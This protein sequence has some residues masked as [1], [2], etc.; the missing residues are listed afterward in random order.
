MVRFVSYNMLNLF[1]G[2]S[3]EECQR[4]D[5]VYQ[6]IREAD[7][8]VLAVQEIIADGE[9][10]AVVAATRVAELAEATGL[11]CQYAPGQVAV[12]IGNHRV[13]VALLWR[14][15]I[16]PAGGWRAYRARICGTFWRNCIWMWV[17]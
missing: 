17:V 13:H 4:R 15:G 8:D 10:K 11:E 9:D 7:P 3:P 14:S 12:A 16:T 6:V 2:D 5:R 1:L